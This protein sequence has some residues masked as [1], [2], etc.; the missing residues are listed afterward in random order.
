MLCVLAIE[1]TEKLK[2]LPFFNFCVTTFYSQKEERV[3]RDFLIDSGSFLVLFILLFAFFKQ[4]L[5]LFPL[6]CV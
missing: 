2:L 4:P 3:L 1:Q 5:F 6:L